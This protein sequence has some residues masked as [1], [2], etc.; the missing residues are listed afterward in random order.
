MQIYVAKQVQQFGPYPLEVINAC[1]ANGTFQL[2]DLAWHQGADN[3]APLGTIPGV[4]AGRRNPSLTAG[5]AK[6]A[7]ASTL[8][9]ATAGSRLS[10]SLLDMLIGCS[11]TLPGIVILFA[12]RDDTTILIVGGAVVVL[13]ALSFAIV[14]LYML[15]VRGQTIGK[16]IMG[17]KIVAFADDSLPGFYKLQVLR[18]L[19]PG[20]LAAIPYLGWIFWIIDSCFIFRD[21]RRCVHDL[22]AGTK[23]VVA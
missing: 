21:D 5:G 4:V 14:Q 2:S 18:S 19:V 15:T 6:L 17:I 23:V 1:V 10:A 7:K 16:R 9:L 11:S 8:R 3:W 20:L 12:K 13:A 22:I